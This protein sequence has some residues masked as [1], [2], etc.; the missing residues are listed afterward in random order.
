VKTEETLEITVSFPVYVTAIISFVGWWFFVIFGGLGMSGLP[1]SLVNDF[2]ERPRNI[3]EDK[4]TKTKVG[5][6][7]QISIL[8]EHGKQLLKKQN[9]LKTS[10]K[11]Y[12]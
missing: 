4:F 2:R 8:I 3:D 9:D 11:G 10:K 1:L 12:C 5:L 6:S 7:G